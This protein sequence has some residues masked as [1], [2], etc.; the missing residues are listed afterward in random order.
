MPYH[1]ASQNIKKYLISD[2]CGQ[3]LTTN[4]NNISAKLCEKFGK[5]F[6]VRC[7]SLL[8]LKY[9]THYANKC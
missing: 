6:M 8:N 2:I 7:F 3:S 5:K 1:L 4:D 9:S